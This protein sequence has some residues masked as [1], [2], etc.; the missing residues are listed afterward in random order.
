[1][2]PVST[3]FRAWSFARPCFLWVVCRPCEMLQG[4]FHDRVRSRDVP[5]RGLQW[6]GSILRIPFVSRKS[7]R[8]WHFDGAPVIVRAVNTLFFILFD[9]SPLLSL[10]VPAPRTL[11]YS[12]LA[13][14]ANLQLSAE[15]VIRELR[16]TERGWVPRR[17]AAVLRDLVYG[18]PLFARSCAARSSEVRVASDR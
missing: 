14:Q 6:C 3:V 2:V 8:P 1:V 4:W 15:I 18:R 17:Y 7:Q 5:R 10:S 11:T 9:L 12:F 16:R 13:I